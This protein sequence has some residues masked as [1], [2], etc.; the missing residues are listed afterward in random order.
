MWK[1]YLKIAWRNITRSKGYALINIAGLGIGMAASILILI[2]VQ[3]ELSVDRFHENSDRVYANWRNA[4]M[5]GEIFTWDYTPA[6]YAAALKEQFPE[7]AEVARITEWDQQ[8]LTVGEKSFYEE[9]TF[10]DPGFFEMFSFEALEGDPIAALTE[11]GNI[12]LTESVAKK[13]F[14]ESSAMGKSVTVE[15]QMDFE[16]KAVIKDLPNNTDFPFTV[17]L[18]FKKLEAMGWA[19][20]Y[21]GNNS[22]RTFTMLN[23]GTDLAGFTQKF[24]DFT[25]KNS[26]MKDVSDFLFPIKDLHLY[27]KFENGKSVGG[28]IELIKMFGIVSIIVL[29]IAAINFVNLSTAQSDK[30][31]KEVGIRKISGAGKGMLIG[32]FL[33]ESILIALTAYILAIVIVSLSFSWFKDLVGQDLENPFTQPFFWGI[34][35]AYIFVTGILAGSYPAFLLSSYK[36]AVVFKSKMNGKKSF[37]LK[38]RE[39]LVVFQFAVVVTL[40]SSVW[41][42]QDQM[43]FVQ[44]RDL[45]I[46]KDNLIFHTVTE[47][48][49]ENKAALRNELLALPEVKSVS[50]TFSPL[51]EIYS[52]TDAMNW[53]G[54]DPEFKTNISRM[55]T[56]A[57][58]VQTAGM[59]LLSGRDIDIYNFPSDSLAAIINEKT[60]A[61]MGFRDPIGQVIEDDELKFTV[62]GVV[63]DF[64]MDSPF[65]N[66]VPIVVMGPKRNL[67]FIH[68]RFAQG[69]DYVN[70]LASVETV[71]NKF[72]PDSPFDYKFV[73]E[74]H[75]QK[76]SSQKRT[77]KLTSLFTGLAVM[78][79]CMGLFGLATF[80]AERR[81]K[82]ISVRK[83]MGASISSVVGL[84]SSEFTKLVLISV[85][86]GIP[87]TW[88][89]MSDWLETF[90]YRTTINWTVFL[91]TGGLTLLIALLTVSSQAIKAA[92]VNPA[93]TLKSE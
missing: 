74:E 17:F 27:A 10:T 16:V 11:P 35:V 79:S 61:V 78:I 26:E 13:L 19:D 59:E 46:D 60:V 77:A 41:I 73:D 45:G 89:F 4:E 8:L 56:D 31:S 50:Y 47:N 48:M 83:V 65:D 39:V 90:A 7:V 70:S 18:P 54:K 38:P 1:N 33:A 44:N 75:A 24:N 81:R 20:D 6:P 64:I 2:W 22:Y 84:I 40:I 30:R 72:N 32:Q 58:L 80:I 63:K 93:E 91:W 9:A 49:R 57:D 92:L 37:G 71:F 76:F 12:I 43:K 69:G 34:S 53:Q 42:V 87:T 88:Y 85:I 15:K 36:P 52:D 51:T 5:Q 55:G 25:A 66:A 82:E 21:W 62:V 86:I 29:L 23:E 28:K 67:N 14:G 3:F 68:I